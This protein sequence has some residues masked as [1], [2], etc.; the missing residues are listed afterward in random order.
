MKL[1]QT[2]LNDHIKANYF[3]L[4]AKTLTENGD[5]VLQTGSAEISI[6][7]VDEVGDEKFLVVTLKVP[8]GSRDGEPYDGY[9]IAE[10]YRLKQIAKAEK[11]AQAEKAK[12][13]KAK[14]DAEMRDKAK[15][16]KA[17]AVSTG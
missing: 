16:N 12:A 7:V 11:K 10:D 3:D 13:E 1:T 15:R 14:R 17:K 8:K 2:T 6:P 5:E 9:G 4:F